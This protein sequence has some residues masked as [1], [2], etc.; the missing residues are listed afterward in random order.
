MKEAFEYFDKHP[1]SAK[2]KGKNIESHNDEPW[3]DGEYDEIE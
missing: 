1:S 3:D 2:R